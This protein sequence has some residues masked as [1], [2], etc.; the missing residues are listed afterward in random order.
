LLAAVTL[1]SAG[2]LA[3]VTATP[4]RAAV[5]TKATIGADRSKIG[6]LERRIETEGAV[7][8]SLVVRENRAETAMAAIKS[9]IGANESLLHHDRSVESSDRT[10][11]RAVA[12]NAYVNGASGLTPSFIPMTGEATTLGA[13]QTYAGVAAGDLNT[14]VAAL[15]IAEYRTTTTQHT[16]Q[17]EENRSAQL[18]SEL[19]T[20]RQ[21]ADLAMQTDQTILGNVRGN[22][23]TLVTKANEAREAAAQEAAEEE[24]AQQAA[25]EQAVSVGLSISSAPTATVNPAPGHYANPLRDVGG[26]VPERI[27]QGVD[28]GGYGPIYAIGNGQVL[29]VYNGGW[30]GGTFIAYRLTDGPAAGLV[31]YAAEDINP[32]VTLGESVTPTTVIGHIYEGPDGIETGWANP[33][34]D[35]TTMAAINDQFSGANSTAFG[36][37]FSALLQSVG[38]PGG[39]PQN[40][41]PS[42]AMPL[43]WPQ[44]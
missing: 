23:L 17:G 31:V 3:V 14:S 4:V 1:G 28:Y 16:L 21:A 29:S 13:E 19:S 34:G 33:S 15:Q 36:A 37:N 44:W 24:L 5:P 30:P 25:A 27:D 40:E 26:L 43:N 35:G 8:Q 32:A 12:V 10:R 38:A 18:L 22:L 2:G 6:A 20:T 41:P 7:V 11:L 42:G 39:V 9:K